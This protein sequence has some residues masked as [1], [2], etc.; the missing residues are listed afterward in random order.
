MIKSRSTGKIEAFKA[1]INGI[2]KLLITI[3]LIVIVGYFIGVCEFSVVKKRSSILE[4]V[5]NFVDGSIGIVKRGY[6][7][8]K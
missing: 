4:D 6:E 5:G 8:I 2:C 1:I 3:S 7:V